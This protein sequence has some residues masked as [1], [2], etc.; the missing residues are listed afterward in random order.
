MTDS[1]GYYEVKVK[2]SASQISIVALG[3]GLIE[4]DI[5][6][7]TQ[8]DFI[9]NTNVIVLEEP[10][11]VVPE[12]ELVNTGYNTVQKKRLTTSVSRVDGTSR[13]RSYS[14][15]YEMLQTVPGVTVTGT[16]VYIQDSKNMYGHIPPLF[17]VDGVPVTSI[18]DVHP[19]QVASIEVLKGTSAAIYGVR[20]YG[21][22]ILIK[23]KS[24]G[25]E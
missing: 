6:E 25:D 23:L 16:N 7:R 10:V 14:S 4:E 22:A 1:K 21:G 2:P 19:S 11:L 12:D 24:F 9:Y 5:A 13:T 18:P 15:I 8:I 20:G 17:I 3:N